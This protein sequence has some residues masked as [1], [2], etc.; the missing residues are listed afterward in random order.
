ME[1]ETFS[2]L[3]HK[4][5]HE[6]VDKIVKL[7]NLDDTSKFKMEFSAGSAKGDN[8]LGIMFRIQIKSKKDNSTKLSLIAKLPP[9]NGA[10]RDELQVGP[11]FNKEILFYDILMP[12]YKNFQEEK[13]IDV[14]TEGFYETPKVYSTINEP[15]HE[16]IFFEDLK[17]RNFEMFDRF[18]DITKEYVIIVMKALAKMHATFF[19]VK[20]QKPD[21]VKQ[22]IG[23]EDF[24]IFLVR[25]GK[26][27]LNAWYEGQKVHA[28]KALEKVENSDLK[29]KIENFLNRNMEDILNEVIG[30]NVAEPYSTI[31]HGDVWNNNMMF[32]LNENGI[33]SVF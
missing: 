15:P 33:Q 25:Q 5:Y 14:Q 22:F 6:V 19:C 30:T 27:L 29:K 12:I 24:F 26:N 28:L 23:M 21:L 9:Q 20:D 7:H 17:V 2:K 4:I 11:A 16:A 1:T 8:Y 18:K 31:C 32:K 13:G 10:R 3:P